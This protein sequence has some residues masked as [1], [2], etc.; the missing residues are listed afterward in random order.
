MVIANAFRMAQTCSDIV[1]WKVAARDRLRRD[2]PLT[3]KRVNELCWVYLADP[4]AL[5]RRRTSQRGYENDGIFD[6][7]ITTAE[8]PI[9]VEFVIVRDDPN[10]PGIEVV[11]AHK[12]D[13]PWPGKQYEDQR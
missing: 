6:V 12:P 9:W 11:S 1:L 5:V 4:D 3:P 8:G 7:V 10:D 2:Y 13:F